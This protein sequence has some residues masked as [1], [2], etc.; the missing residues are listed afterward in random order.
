MGPGTRNSARSG[1]KGTRNF[2]PGLT[3]TWQAAY[4]QAA[5]WQAALDGPRVPRPRPGQRYHMGGDRPERYFGRPVR[6]T[7][8]LVPIGALSPA[9]GAQQIQ[10]AGGYR[11]QWLSKYDADTR[12]FHSDCL[13]FQTTNGS[14][15]VVNGTLSCRWFCSVAAACPVTFFCRLGDVANCFFTALIP[16]LLCQKNEKRNKINGTPFQE[17]KP[18]PFHS[19]IPPHRSTFQRLHA[20]PPKTFTP[21]ST[22]PPPGSP[23]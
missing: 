21:T 14:S 9:I 18:C 23:R 11:S 12:S 19:K 16:D 15:E 10:A 17:I 1:G 2:H 13:V 7:A 3:T 20:S 8:Y 5:D 22:C 6:F 4:W